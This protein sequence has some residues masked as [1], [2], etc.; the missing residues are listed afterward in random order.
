M[1]KVSIAKWTEIKRL[2]TVFCSATSLLINAQKTFFLQYGVQQQV[3]DT[4]KVSF[5][6]NFHD[7]TDGFRYLG[8][9]LKIER[10]KV[11]H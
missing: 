2:L 3:L 4:L 5:L 1:T 8:Y 9:F 7:L 10:Y 11:E 6:Y